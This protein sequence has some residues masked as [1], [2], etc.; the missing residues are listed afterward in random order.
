MRRKKKHLSGF[1]SVEFLSL[2]QCLEG[3]VLDVLLLIV[4][5]FET[6]GSDRRGLTLA[7]SLK[8]NLKSV[9]SLRHCPSREIPTNVCSISLSKQWHGFQC[10]GFLTRAHNIC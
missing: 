6:S 4:F 10:L 8:I 5:S 2:V 3:S 1:G 9:R 7:S